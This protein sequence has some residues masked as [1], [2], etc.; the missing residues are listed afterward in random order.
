[1]ILSLQHEQDI[2][3]MGGLRRRLPL[4]FWAFL[5]GAAALASVPLVTS[6]FYSKEQILAGAWSAER[7]AVWLGLA[8]LAAAF[9]TSVYIFRAVFIV[10]FGAPATA[11]RHPDERDTTTPGATAATRRPVDRTS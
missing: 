4:V 9:L 5:I 11:G 2:F 10:F 8:G 3:R 6:G 1:L 7:G